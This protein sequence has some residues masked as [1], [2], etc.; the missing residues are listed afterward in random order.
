MQPLLEAV[1]LISLVVGV[2]MRPQ[3]VITHQVLVVLRL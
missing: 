3:F 2:E 1:Q